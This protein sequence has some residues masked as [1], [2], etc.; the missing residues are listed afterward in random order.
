MLSQG[1]QDGCG[2]QAGGPEQFSHGLIRPHP[3]Q[4][5]CDEE[6]QG[7]SATIFSFQAGER[8]LRQFERIG[9]RDTEQL[10]HPLRQAWRVA[11]QADMFCV[12]DSSQPLVELRRTGG[13]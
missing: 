11:D 13:D 6:F 9:G 1:E 12:R 2:Q 7:R 8:A 10:P 3:E 4:F 5:G